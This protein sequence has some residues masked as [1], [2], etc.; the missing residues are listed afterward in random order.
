[1][2]LNAIST[3]L[4]LAAALSE[5]SAPTVFGR[6]AACAYPV[7][8]LLLLADQACL[9]LDLGDPLRFHHMLRVFKPLS[10][11]SLGTWL[12]TAYTFPLAAAGA[13]DVLTLLG[14]LPAGSEAVGWTRSV[15]VAAGIPFAFG[16]AAY[17]GVLFSTSAQP[18]WRDARW[19]GGYHII[20]ALALGTAGLLALALLAGQDQAVMVL[21]LAAALLLGLSLVP[22]ALITAEMWAP[23]KRRYSGRQLAALGGLAYL[24][25]VFAPLAALALGA[26][27]LMLAGAMLALA[28]GL[29]SRYAIVMLPQPPHNARL[30]HRLPARKTESV[31]T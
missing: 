26:P 20:S 5:L 8:V 7:A 15:F 18:G 4:F 27:S 10:P 21:R 24:G 1:M 28:G 3:G 25:G 2:F 19:L 9:V 16:T 17:K 23:L 12:L 29:A 13:I 6:V 14:I 11:M 31:P 30:S 22:Q